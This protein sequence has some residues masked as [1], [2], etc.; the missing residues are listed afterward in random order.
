MANLTLVYFWAVL[1]IFFPFSSDT[2]NRHILIHNYQYENILSFDP[3]S[4][5][6]HVHGTKC[7]GWLSPFGNRACHECARARAKCSKGRVCARCSSRGL[8]CVYPTRRKSKK[9]GDDISI[10][11]EA[12]SVSSSD[13]L[14]SCRAD[15]GRRASARSDGRTGSVDSL[16]M[17]IDPYPIQQF[18]T[19]PAQNIPPPISTP[20]MY[21]QATYPASL[22]ST[23]SIPTIGSPLEATFLKG[24]SVTGVPSVSVPVH[25]NSF[26]QHANIIPYPFHASGPLCQ[27]PNFINI[28]NIP[29]DASDPFDPMLEMPLDWISSTAPPRMMFDTGFEYASM[30]TPPHYTPY[31][32]QDV[33]ISS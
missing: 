11:V 5:P 20:D 21:G 2:L 27:D 1:N 19:T 3:I 4:D 7:K 6:S 23:D 13:E 16:E 18:A 10:S 26:N 15:A 9:H 17:D 12:I 25:R 24:G 8:S 31:R 30:Q 29:Y 22:S 28:C 32:R 33:P 14:E